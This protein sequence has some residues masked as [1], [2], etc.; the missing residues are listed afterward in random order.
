MEGGSGMV[1]GRTGSGVGFGT[2][3]N[4]GLPRAVRGLRG[5]GAGAGGAGDFGLGLV[6]VNPNR[7]TLPAT[8]LRL[9]PRSSAM[10]L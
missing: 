7:F 8:A 6:T 4:N 3:L 9:M 5:A 2:A 10:C 1:R